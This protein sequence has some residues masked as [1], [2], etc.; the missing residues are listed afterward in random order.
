MSSTY[1]PRQSDEGAG[2][3]WAVAVLLG[4]LVAVLGF[5]L[6]W[7]DAHKAR[8]DADEAASAATSMPGM[9]MAASATAGTLTSY[10]GAAP[11][12]ADELA[13]AHKPY[14]AVLPAYRQDRSL[15]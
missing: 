2:F 12:N 15:P 13:A 9:D 10:A 8:T 14:S 1:A 7:L 4:I 3:A 11:A 6:M 5:F